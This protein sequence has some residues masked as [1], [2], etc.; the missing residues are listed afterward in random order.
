VTEKT[1][2]PRR[3]SRRVSSARPRSALKP[4]GIRTRAAIKAA[5]RDVL[6]EQGF[7]QLRMQ[8]VAARAGVSSSVL[9]HYFRDLRSVVAELAEDLFE[10]L[11][12]AG[13]ARADTDDAYEWILVTLKD[14]VHH[15]GSNPGI[16]G[17]LFGLAG[18]YQEFDEIWKKNAHAWNLRVAGFL[19]ARAGFSETQASN[20]A[21]ALGAVTEG[22]IYQVFIRH[23]E[24]LATFSGSTDDTA[25]LIAT[26]WYRT[27]FLESP[28]GDK[29][30]RVTRQ[31]SNSE[32][33]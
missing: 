12:R 25:E 30:S 21:F 13:E 5:A 17:C 28:P 14:A 9:Y 26:L 27:I 22:I 1:A 15:L 33:D 19:T 29:I 4:K 8:D 11:R 20:M 31:L 23:T 10:D 6:N 2:A 3:R 24:D 7:R 32:D 18:D 16:L